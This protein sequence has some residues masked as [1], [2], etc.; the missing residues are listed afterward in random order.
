M[1]GD[2]INLA[3]RNAFLKLEIEKELFKSR[4]KN[5]SFSIQLKHVSVVY[6]KLKCKNKDELNKV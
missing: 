2:T 4:A 1:R 5:I 6:C 3:F